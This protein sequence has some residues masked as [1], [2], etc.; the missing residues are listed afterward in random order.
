MLDSPWYTILLGKF[1]GIKHTNFLASILTSIYSAGATAVRRSATRTILGGGYADV[2]KGNQSEILS[3]IPGGPAIQQR[4]VDGGDPSGASSPR[5]LAL[6]T[7]ELARLRRCVVVTT[8]KTDLVTAGGS[9][10]AVDNGHAYLGMVTGTG[11]CLGTTISA[12]VAAHP[13]D[14]LAAT[15]AGVLLYNIAAEIAAERADVRGPGTFVPAFLDELY[16]ARIA[17]VKGSG[18]D[19][20]LKRASVSVVSLD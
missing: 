9:V 16:N 17:A 18:E 6:A 4:G 13:N 19:A 11:C 7:R 1:D 3:C 2:I 12:M 8:G 15:L 10:Y 14:K 5:E 20:W